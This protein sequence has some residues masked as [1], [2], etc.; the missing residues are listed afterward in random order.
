MKLQLLT[1]A[2]VLALTA[3][4]AHAQTVLNGYAGG[5]VDYSSATIKYD[6]ESEHETDKTTGYFFDSAVALPVV[7]IFG[8]QADLAYHNFSD[9]VSYDGGHYGYHGDG[10]IATGHV[11]ARTD[12]WLL[13]AFVGSDDAGLG[14]TQGG[15]IEGQ[16]Y[17]GKLTLMGSLG[18]ASQT[19]EYDDGFK[20]YV[21]SGRID[22]RYFITD[23]LMVGAHAGYMDGSNSYRDGDY[24]EQYK[25]P[26]LWTVGVGAEY[27]IPSTPF[28]VTANYEHGDS[29]IRDSYYYEGEGDHGSDNFKSQGDYGAIGVRWTFGGSLLNR[30]RHG[31]SLNTMKDM[32][33]GA[34][35]ET[36]ADFEGE[37]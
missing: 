30:D 33:G 5:G 32:F 20:P 11:F 4:S 15:G 3:S 31:A 13:G 19:Y 26:G 8:A 2:S 1:A 6:N 29:T 10:M 12:Q 27:K 34:F 28:T 16:Y 21:V 17:L 14:K 35:G 9:R 36:L 25:A 22:A 23:D 18:A 7:G 37:E 24:H